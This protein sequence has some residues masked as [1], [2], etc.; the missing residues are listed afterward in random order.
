VLFVGGED[1]YNYSMVR[2]AIERL[3]S[4]FDCW[5]CHWTKARHPHSRY[6][7]VAAED[8]CPCESGRTYRECC[9]N[10]DGVLRPQCDID[11]AKNPGLP[12]PLRYF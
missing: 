1:T 4:P 3:E 6:S 7:Q 8:A 9:Q 10:E 12:S 11:F 2:Y 5:T